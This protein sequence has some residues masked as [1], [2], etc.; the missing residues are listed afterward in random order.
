MKQLTKYT[1]NTEL[2]HCNL[3]L[4]SHLIQRPPPLLQRPRGGPRLRRPSV[5]Y[6]FILLLCCYAYYVYYV[7]DVY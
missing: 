4:L 2:V 7:Y 3:K 6:F 1:H 5:L